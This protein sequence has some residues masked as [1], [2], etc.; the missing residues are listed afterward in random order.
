MYRD[1]EGDPPALVCQVGSTTLRYRLQAIEDLHEWLRGQG[2]WVVLGA[3]DE[4]KPAAEG[5]VEAWGRSANNPVGGCTGFA[6]AIAVVS[7]CICHR[8]SRSWDLP[9]SLMTAG[10]IRCARVERGRVAHFW[11]D[12]PNRP[13]T[14]EKRTADSS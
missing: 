6:T 14:T 9:R 5:T 4:K 7:E 3:A 2:E 13:W 12:R 8:F 10:T 11:P 1:E